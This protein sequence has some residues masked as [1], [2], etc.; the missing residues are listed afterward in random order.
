MSKT[1]KTNDNTFYGQKISDYGIEH[2]RV[3]YGT[4]AKIGSSMLCNEIA[5]I[6]P[7]IWDNV[8]NG[9]LEDENGNEVEIFQLYIIDGYLCRILERWTDELILWSPK[10]G[11]CVW[12]IKHCGIDWD[13]VLTDIEVEEDHSSSAPEKNIFSIFSEI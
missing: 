13:Y 11:L 1:L 4:L 12:C 2:H 3:D 9:S 8:E 5:E 6:D 10:S 7:E